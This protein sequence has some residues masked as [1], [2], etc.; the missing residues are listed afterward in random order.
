M[1]EPTLEPITPRVV[2]D[3]KIEATPAVVT[4]ISEAMGPDVSDE[5]VTSFLAALN[6]VRAG[7][8][9]GR[10]CRSPRSGEVAHRVNDGGLHRWR[11]SPPDAPIYTNDEPNLPGWDIIYDPEEV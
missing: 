2:V 8:P 10:V 4:R 7:D 3:D 9:L 6:S 5:D 1:T 11:I